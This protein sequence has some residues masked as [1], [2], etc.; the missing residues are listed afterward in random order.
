MQS[1]ILLLTAAGT[2]TG[3]LLEFL[4][5]YAVTRSHDARE[6]TLLCEQKDIYLVLVEAELDTTSG[7]DW[8]GTIRTGH[9][10]LNGL[11]IGNPVEEGLLRRALEAGFSGI[12][13]TPV[14]GEQLRS[15]V[16]RAMALV[17]LQEENTRLRTLVP[18]YSL[19]EKFLQSAS[20][21]EVL[22]SLLNVV[23]EQTGAAQVSVMLFDEEESCLRIAACRGM[24]EALARSIRI[25]PGDQIAG[26]V[27]ARGR[28]VL[29][30]RENQ[31]DSI[32][33]PLLKRPD[34]VAA[35]S[36]PLKV[37]DRVL[38]VLNISRTESGAPYTEA[39]IEMLAVI[40]SQATMALENVRATRLMAEKVRMRTLFEQYVAPEVADLLIASDA[41]L[42]D[43][44]EIRDVTVLFA[45]IRNFT[46]L[47]QHMELTE[48]RSFLNAFFQIFTDAIFQHRGTVDKF[49]GDAVLAVFGAPIL[50]EN[51]CLSAVQTA[52]AIR[53]RFGGLRA[54]WASRCSEFD[55]VDLGIGITRGEMFLGNVGSSRRLD[56]TVIGSQVNIA[57]RLAAESTACQIY[58]TDTVRREIEPHVAVEHTGFLRLRGVD[59]KIGVHA[60]RGDR[61]AVA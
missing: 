49:M 17:R 53:N 37:R 47:V 31:D 35:I 9:P 42:L 11:L 24:D 16:E 15:Q 58:V 56:Y 10:H 25:L 3:L 44:G 27:Y 7:I 33:A 60:V 48:L 39:D 23:V 46:A 2:D 26:W 54:Q 61:D 30:N 36:F 18:L 28:P 29:L 21:K 14:R 19:G 40:C 8:F 59:R 13:E 38:G 5:G 6:A 4:D 20:E 57:Q 22:D 52:L 12:I 45:D 55:N 32:F 50:L 51:A 43:L 1:D 41:N 34:I